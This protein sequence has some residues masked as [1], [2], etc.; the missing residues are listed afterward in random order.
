MVY[1]CCLFMFLIAV[2]KLQRGYPCWAWKRDR[3]FGIFLIFWFLEHLSLLVFCNCDI[4]FNKGSIE[5]SIGKVAGV[6]GFTI[7]VLTLSPVR[8]FCA[9]LFEKIRKKRNS[10]GPTWWR[11]IAFLQIP[12]KLKPWNLNFHVR[13]VLSSYHLE[14]LRT[15]LKFLRV[16]IVTGTERY[17]VLI[18]PSLHQQ[19]ST[20][21]QPGIFVGHETCKF[22]GHVSN[23]LHNWEFLER[24][25]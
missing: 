2:L 13:K 10:T 24:S 19:R 8:K 3:F 18:W 4:R 12:T 17:L 7:A 1:Y 20:E 9:C 15:M 11:A 23:F 21:L 6:G 22:I 25:L 5:F 14:S 16:A